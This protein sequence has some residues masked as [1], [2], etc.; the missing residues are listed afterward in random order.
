MNELIV[1]YVRLPAFHVAFVCTVSKTPEEESLKK[2]K[3]WAESK[4]YWNNPAKHLLFGYN[5]PS[6]TPGK[7]EYGYEVILTVY[8]D[9]KPEGEVEIKKIPGG[10]YAVTRCKGAETFFE[11]WMALYNWIKNTEYELDENNVPGLEEH[12]NRNETRFS[13]Y[14]LDLYLSIKLRKK[15]V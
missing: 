12:L 11:T 9:V 8:P 13:E 2:I 1:R 15:A 5:N 3:A 10:L 6:P 14:L 4:G 7:D